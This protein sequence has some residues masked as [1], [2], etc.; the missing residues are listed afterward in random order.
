MLILYVDFVRGYPY[1]LRDG[2]TTAVSH[3]LWMNAYDYDA[4]TQ[5]LKVAE[6]N[7][8]YHDMTQTIPNKVSISYVSSPTS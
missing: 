4:P 7:T 3:G 6:R 1:S 5:L 2:V 8:R